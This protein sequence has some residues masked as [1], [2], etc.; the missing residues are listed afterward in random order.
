MI[1][2]FLK[3]DYGSEDIKNTPFLGGQSTSWAPCHD[4]FRHMSV[5]MEDLTAWIK[6]FSDEQNQRAR[7]LLISTEAAGLG[8]DLSC[9]NKL[10]IF[11]SS[12]NPTDVMRCVFSL[13]RLC[14]KKTL[15]RL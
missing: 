4:Y 3:K 9:L 11:D 2:H 10:I 13:Y 5:S 14:Q 7:L 1:E 8:V 15:S 12:W 6:L